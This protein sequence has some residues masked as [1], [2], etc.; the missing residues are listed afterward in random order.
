MVGSIVEPYDS[1]RSFPVYGF[2]GVPRHMGM[3]AVNHCFPI[4]GILEAPEIIGIDQ[5]V[6]CYRA[7]LPNINLSGPTLFGPLL[8]QFL[9]YVRAL[10]GQTVYNI[11]LLL[12][13]GIINDMAETIRLLVDL[14]ALPCSIIIVG[15]G[16]AD[17]SQMEDLDGDGQILRDDRGRPCMR[18]IVQFV[19][20]TECVARGNLAEE[21]L[22]EVPPQ[23]CQHMERIG[24]RPQAVVLP[25]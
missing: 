18:D 25:Q 8:N 14:S 21:V 24:F 9:Q 22:K 19:R 16:N 2:G 20:F 11:M 13:D 6:A 7:T 10:E 1:D 3:N 4:N 5:I 17:F 12:T 23:F 15:V